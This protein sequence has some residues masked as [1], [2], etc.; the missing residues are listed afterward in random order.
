MAHH[1]GV[2]QNS[3][4]SEEKNKA[5]LVKQ[6][7]T[8]FSFL[9]EIIFGIAPFSAF[10]A[11]LVDYLSVWCASHHTNPIGPLLPF[12]NPYSSFLALFLSLCFWRARSKR[13]K[14]HLFC[15]MAPIV[16]GILL[17]RGDGMH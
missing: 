2:K 9:G 3:T 11:H 12:P 6:H 14:E 1:V 5:P 15:V 17:G 10:H 8:V 13:Q 16:Q 4:L 7:S